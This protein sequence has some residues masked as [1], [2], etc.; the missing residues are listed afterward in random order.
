MRTKA[1]DGDTKASNLRPKLSDERTKPFVN[2]T[3]A[4]RDYESS[5]LQTVSQQL[6]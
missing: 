2:V 1:L 5:E 4:Y 3:I 6:F